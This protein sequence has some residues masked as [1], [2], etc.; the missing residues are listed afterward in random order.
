MAVV[1]AQTKLQLLVAYASV[2][3]VVMLSVT[4]YNGTETWTQ[5]FHLGDNKCSMATIV[6]DIFGYK[7]ST[8]I[9]NPHNMLQLGLRYCL[10]NS[11]STL[12]N[13]CT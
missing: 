12:G 10:P 5:E 7:L 4:V 8:N 11:Y 2:A 9:E 3:V 1:R 13:D 6:T